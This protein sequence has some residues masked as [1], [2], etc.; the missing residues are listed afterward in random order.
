[1]SDL[2]MRF[3][4]AGTA[5]RLNMVGEPENEP[6]LRSLLGDEE[7]A[8]LVRLA[9]GVDTEH[10]AFGD[11]PNLVFIPGVMGS[12]LMSRTLGGVWWI[13]ARTRNRLNH[14][15][16]APDGLADAERSHD[17]VSFTVDT[18]YETFLATALGHPDLTP[19]NFHYDWR[20]PL[21]ASSERLR[22]LLLGLAQEARGPVH[23]IAHSMGGLMARIALQ[24]HPELWNVVGRIVFVGTPHYGSPA[25]AGYLKNHFSGFNLMALL[26]RYIDRPTF[27][28]MWGPI[29]LLPAP[30][31]IYPGTRDAAAPWSSDPYPHPAS[32][33]DF[34]DAAAWALDL[35][36]EEEAHL[37]RV[38]DAAAEFHRRLYAWHMG[39][40]Q[41]RRD[42]MAVIAGIGVQTL[43]RLA[44]PT[45]LGRLVPF[46]SMEKVTGR[47]A[48][49]VH[50]EGDG[51][52]P[53]ASA[54][55]EFVGETRYVVGEH[56]QLPN[57]ADVA[58]DAL[59][60]VGGEPMELPR[61]ARAALQGHL[62][63]GGLPAATTTGD[64]RLPAVLG[65][66]P[67]YL[68]FEAPPDEELEAL[69]A[70]L[71]AGSLHAFRQLRLL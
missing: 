19:T 30:L 33:Y 64:G 31:G 17:V 51:R 66:D 62:G 2:T 35:A 41:E 45:G 44:Y 15:R 13:D 63:T 58:A 10:L 46:R 70:A 20:K 28:S 67:G 21:S 37:Q 68:A 22:D 26:G 61:S 3:L 47:R 54:E 39:L 29:S 9:S 23:V 34:Y 6:E 18:S 40:D 71:A 49:N 56:A 7:Y 5:Q 16:L 11:P 60:F 12:L 57:L 42:R 14:L 43:F 48:G 32:N 59:A 65:E 55:L 1:M 25:I 4:E 50:R 24:R 69:D 27:R 8:A 38:L 52:V 53:L 36:P